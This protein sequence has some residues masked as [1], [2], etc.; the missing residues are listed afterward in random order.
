M[1]NLAGSVLTELQVIVGTPAERVQFV[2]E[3]SDQ[4]LHRGSVTSESPVVVNIPSFLDF[5]VLGNDFFERNKGIRIASTDGNPI[6]VLGTNSIDFFN[7]GTFLA[8]PCQLDFEQDT[9]EYLILSVGDTALFSQ[10]LLV[11]CSDDTIISIIPTQQVIIPEDAQ[12]EDSAE[13]TVEKDTMHNVT[14]NKMN[15]LLVFSADQD[16]TGTRI[17]SN[18]PLTVIGGHECANVP[19]VS[20]D[21]EPIAIQI[22]PVSTWGTSFLVAGYAGRTSGQLYFRIVPSQENTTLEA[23][24][25]QSTIALLKIPSDFFLNSEF[26]FCFLQ[27]NKPVFLAQLAGGSSTETK[28]KG[29]P[30]I[31]IV[32]PIDQY[33]NKIEFVL[34]PT[35]D[36][37]NSYISITVPAEHYDPDSILLDGEKVNCEWIAIYNRSNVIVGYGCNVSMPAESSEEPTQHTLSHSSDD[38]RLSATVYG[39]STFPPQGYAY[40]TGQKLEITDVTGKQPNSYMH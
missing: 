4:E 5:Q 3:T 19:Q 12:V 18:K 38:G 32:S 31:S 2:V 26:P 15:T 7:Y 33:V 28:G 29:D 35:D 10:F 39:F 24:C 25:G 8:Y 13:T 9:Y 16:L 22:P 17:I 21:C 6:F 30:A 36:F 1:Q 11:G 34:L 23:T 37:P 14:L 40:L 27:F 20:F